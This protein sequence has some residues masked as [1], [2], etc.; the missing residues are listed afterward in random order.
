MTSVSL[1]QNQNNIT[2][3]MYTF[4]K[5]KN[6]K[7]LV[8][9][10]WASSHIFPW[11]LAFFTLWQGTFTVLVICKGQV[12]YLSV[13]STQNKVHSSFCCVF[14]FFFWNIFCLEGFLKKIL[15]CF[16][17]LKTCANNNNNNTYTLNHLKG[18]LPISSILEALMD[19]AFVWLLQYLISQGTVRWS[20]R[21]K[22]LCIGFLVLC[23]TFL[24]SHA[25]VFM[26]F[27]HI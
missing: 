6:K 17:F 18:N 9:R 20:A 5:N 26:Y 11:L 16:C 3:Q 10:Y 8:L 27:N 14:F 19:E 12:T 23:T 7:L 1:G 4:K 24:L 21:S 15:F 13:Q 2:F 25:Q 22:K